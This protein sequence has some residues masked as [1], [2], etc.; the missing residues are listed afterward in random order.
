M[1]KLFS[2]IPESI[3]N[4]NAIVDKIEVLN[5][6][7]DILLPAFPVPKEFQ[8]RNFRSMLH[9]QTP[10]N[11][12][13]SLYYRYWMNRGD[14]NVAAH[15]GIRTLEYKL[16]YYY[17]DGLNLPGTEGGPADC[18]SILGR[19]P[20][21]E[22]FDLQNDPREMNNVANDPAYADIRRQL[23]VE[24]HRLQAELGDQR[25]AADK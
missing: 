24:L 13:Q 9:G 20:E 25:Y 23:T 19:K 18:P 3:D 11:W 14:H 5:L 6:K 21:W 17:Y 10:A 8:G 22:L 16:V 1:K 7:K 4:T 12:R 15:Y 2:D